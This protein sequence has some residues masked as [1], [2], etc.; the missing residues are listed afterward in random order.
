MLKKIK[1]YVSF[2]KFASGDINN[3]ELLKEI[4]KT[5]KDVVISSGMANLKKVKIVYFC[6]FLQNKLSY[7]T[8]YLAIIS[9]KDANLINIEYLKKI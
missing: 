6:F 7:Y 9:K 4:S 1:N 3:L 5:K 8:A 2:F